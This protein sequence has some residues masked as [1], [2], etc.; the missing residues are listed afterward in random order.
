M[1]V[2]LLDANGN[3][4]TVDEADA[5]AGLLDGRYRV[6]SGEVR[7]VR[8]DGT[9]GT[10]AADRLASA[11]SQTDS[12]GRPIFG[13]DTPRAAEERRLQAEYG[14]SEV[15]AGLAGVGRGLTLGLSDQAL[16]AIGGEQTEEALREMRRRN[17]LSSTVGEI[18]GALAPLLL[19]GGRAGAPQVGAAARTATGVLRGLSAPARL[20][21]RAGETAEAG[22]LAAMGARGGTSVASRVLR[23]GVSMGVGGAA[24]GGL[25]GIGQVLTEDALGEAPI[26]A[27]RLVASVGLNALLGGAAGTALGGGGALL[28]AGLQAGGRR[29]AQLSSQASDTIARAWQSRTGTALRPGVGELYAR[30]ASLASGADAATIRRFT[31]LGPEGRR[32]R[33]IVSR[34][35]GVLEDGTRRIREDL[36]QL[37]AVSTHVQD[38]SRGQMKRNPIARVIRSDTIAEQ[39]EAAAGAVT[40]AREL[41]DDI[42]ANPHIYSGV[43]GVAQGR[44][45][46]RLIDG[47]SNDLSSAASRAA[48]EPAEAA[49]DAFISLDRL[50][51]Q[52]GRLQNRTRDPEA[53]AALRSLYDDHFRPLL[54]RAD[55]WG[56]EVAALQRETNAA[57]TRY[58]TRRQDFERMF[59]ADGDRDMVDAFRRL[60]EGDPAK[61][62]AFLGRVGTAANDRSEEIF[63]EMLEAQAQLSDRIVQHFDV[64]QDLAASAMNARS[65]IARIRSTLDEVTDSA[66]TLNQFRSLNTGSDIERTITATAAGTVLGGPAG[67]VVAGA[68]AA[69]QQ[70]VRV[71]AVVDRLTRQV[72]DRIAKSVRAFFL[73]GAVKVGQAVGR[74]VR[75]LPVVTVQVYS[76]KVRQLRE[77]QSD[78]AAMARLL[79]DQTSGLSE[80]APQ[81]QAALQQ[82]AVRA[83]QYL[84]SQ[85]PPAQRSASARLRPDARERPPSR[86]EMDRFLRRVRAVEDPMSMLDDLQAGRLRRAAVESVQAVYPELYQRIVAEVM[87]QSAEATAEPTYA[88][89]VALGTLLGA[90]TDPTLRPEFVAGIQQL[91][92]AVGTSDPIG[93]AQAGG[94]AQPQQRQ[95]PDLAG[96]LGTE[97]QRIAART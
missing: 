61:L 34:G 8:R 60:S 27:E 14:D 74:A 16:T 59:L 11:L 31:D 76:A 41:A 17:P 89:R 43:G 95:A 82:T 15:L 20:A 40:R 93:Q 12:D 26:T 70:V 4:V 3:P 13:F 52:I 25:Q 57:W 46:S 68:L 79:G 28:G 55:L 39:M 48:R 7:L 10:V 96:Q 23:R 47:F 75:R 42:L 32:A 92:A 19:S 6:G 33:E 49:T 22:A 44:N 45:L 29:V 87:R 83:T 53:Q 35:D 18:G 77:A 80:H 94:M 56:D 38:F 85:M 90:P 21:I 88:Q 67:A 66:A 71:M 51:R 91:H 9:A 72:D 50:K 2:T 54:E 73:A 63:R 1:P 64:P 62:R 97:T 81:V 84:V 69:P 24:E 58:L 36:T 65:G 5:R 86:P 37:E 78:P 30:A